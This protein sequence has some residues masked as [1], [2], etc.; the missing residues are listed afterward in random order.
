VVDAV[1]REFKEEKFILGPDGGEVSLYMLGGDIESMEGMERG[2]VEY[3]LNP[4]LVKHATRAA[5]NKA[6]KLDQFYIREGQDGIVWPIDFSS[7]AGSLISPEMFREFCLP[8][9]KSRVKNLKSHGIRI[10]KHA[11]G[12]NVKLMDMFVEAGY[13]GY[14]AI[15]Q[16]AGMN[17]GWLKETYGDRLVLWGGVNVETMVGGSPADVRSDVRKAISTLKP[18]GGHIFGTSHSIAIGTSY[19]NFMAMVDEYHKSCSY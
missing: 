8:A 17:L 2:L 4:D 9:I 13:E 5:L 14:Q 11:C 6:N 16:T 10:L 3:A 18:G 1:I 19:E 12:N 7:T 15:Q